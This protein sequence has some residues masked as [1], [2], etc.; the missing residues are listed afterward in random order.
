METNVAI[1]VQRIGPYHDARFRAFASAWRGEVS[2]VEF[3]PQDSVYAWAEVQDAGG[4]RRLQTNSRTE[5]RRALDEVRP[6]VVVCVGYADPEINQAMAWAFRRKAPLVTCSDSTRD[7]EPRHRAREALK[8]RMIELFDAALISGSSAREYMGSLGLDDGRVFGPWDV[9]DN[10]YFEEGADRSRCDSRARRVRLDR[11]SR[12]FFCVARFVPKKNL[13]G[14]I[15]AY[16]RYAVQAGEHAWPLVLSGSGPLDGALRAQAAALGVGPKVVFTG[17]LQYA[18]LPDYYGLASAFVLPSIS[19]QWGLVVNEAMA[20]GLPV[21]V[22]SRCGCA[23]DLV[24][25]GEN[26]FKFEPG[27]P[28]VLAACLERIA[29]LDDGH[30][31]AMGMRSREIISRFSPGVF[32]AGLEA[33]VA[34]ALARRGALK[35]WSARALVNLS[36]LRSPSK[37]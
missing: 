7:D 34:C 12:Y 30:L 11:P 6:Q 35:P 18:E 33:A 20:A 19:D 23:R 26:G 14:L 24:R 21:I 37:D 17:F 5:L 25:D 8:R 2:V 3:R 28:D 31:V 15:D 16:A 22:S 29:R 13:A 36:A 10:A 9:V 27:E 4:Y 32:A 1:F